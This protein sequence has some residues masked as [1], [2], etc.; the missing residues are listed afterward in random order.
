M[1][2]PDPHSKESLAWR[3]LSEKYEAL[4]PA[5]QR[6]ID[7]LVAIR[8][9]NKSSDVALE[10]RHDGSLTGK[11]YVT[12]R[13]ANHTAWLAAIAEYNAANAALNMEK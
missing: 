3:L 10:A 5:A 8:A 12:F 2:E 11:E 13:D 9:L 4:S 7:S 6:L 1:S